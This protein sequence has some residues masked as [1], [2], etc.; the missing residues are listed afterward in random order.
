M[1]YYD[2]A[3]YKKVQDYKQANYKFG[4]LTFLLT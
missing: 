2:L 4:N 1:M 3:D